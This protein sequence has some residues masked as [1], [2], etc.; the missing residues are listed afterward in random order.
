MNMSI[1]PL[2]AAFA[3]FLLTTSMVPNVARAESCA[4]LANELLAWVMNRGPSTATEERFVQFVLV[5]NQAQPNQYAGYSQGRLD[6]A[7]ESLYGKAHVYL[8][9]IYFGQPL[10]SNPNEKI[11][12]MD[13][14]GDQVVMVNKLGEMH[15]DGVEVKQTQCNDRVIYGWEEL[16]VGQTEGVYPKTFFAMSLRKMSQPKPLSVKFPSLVIIPQLRE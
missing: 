9:P 7:F 11:F 13:P 3:I 1:I 5:S 14:Y 4:D 15:I 10:P 6:H 12:A 2:F 16:P 8:N